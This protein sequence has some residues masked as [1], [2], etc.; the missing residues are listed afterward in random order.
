VNIAKLPEILVGVIILMG[1][2]GILRFN[3]SITFS[4][5]EFWP[6][7]PPNRSSAAPGIRPQ[8]V[9]APGAVYLQLSA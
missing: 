4:R 1:V 8:Q 2:M 7:D 5:A 3:R 9:R 6:L